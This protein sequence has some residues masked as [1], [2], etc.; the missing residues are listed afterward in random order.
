[1]RIYFKPGLK[2]VK[3]CHSVHRFVTTSIPVLNSLSTGT[4]QDGMHVVTNTGVRCI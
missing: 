4:L 2:T 1:M 3:V